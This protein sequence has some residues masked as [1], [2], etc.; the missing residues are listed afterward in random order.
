MKKFVELLL[1]SSLSISLAF[2]A[3]FSKKAMKKFKFSKKC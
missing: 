1:A 3:D 2:G